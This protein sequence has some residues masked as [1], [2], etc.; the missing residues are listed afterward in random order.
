MAA[1]T[2]RSSHRGVKLSDSNRSRLHKGGPKFIGGS[3]IH[4]GFDR[5]PVGLTSSTQRGRNVATIWAVR[6]DVYVCIGV[7]YVQ[8]VAMAHAITAAWRPKARRCSI[9]DRL[10]TA[11]E[12]RRNAQWPSCACA[13]TPAAGHVSD[14]PA[15]VLFLSCP[16]APNAN[17]VT[18]GRDGSTTA[19]WCTSEPISC[20]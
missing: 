5:F 4:A 6:P 8:V 19:V 14:N 17:V 12:T 3:L 10:G 20:C 2:P 9:S 7:A 18:G 11:S 15:N 1:E 13:P 16:G